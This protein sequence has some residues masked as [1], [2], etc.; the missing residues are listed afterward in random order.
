MNYDVFK[1]IILSCVFAQQQSL[2]CRSILTLLPYRL[3][4]LFTPRHLDM[5]GQPTEALSE[6]GA[7][8]LVA[9]SVPAQNAH[10]TE[11]VSGQERK[12]SNKKVI[13]TKYL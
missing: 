9:D 5:D 7:A 2:L 3:L 6:P 12:N 8:E 10:Q 1:Y 4:L 13:I 11:L